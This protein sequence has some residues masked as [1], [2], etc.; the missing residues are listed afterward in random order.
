[1]PRCLMCGVF[2]YLSRRYQTEVQNVRVVPLE[3]SL[4]FAILEGV[5]FDSYFSQVNQTTY[6]VQHPLEERTTCALNV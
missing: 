6:K 4:Y 1:M 5:G 3:R 2:G